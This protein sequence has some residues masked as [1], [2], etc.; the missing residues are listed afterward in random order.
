MAEIFILLKGCYWGARRCLWGERQQKLSKGPGL[1]Q[2]HYTEGGPMAQRVFPKK[3]RRQFHQGEYQGAVWKKKLAHP[4]KQG[5]WWW[6]WP[7]W[8]AAE[9]DN[10]RHFIKQSNKI[11][12]HKSSFKSLRL[13]PPLHTAHSLE[14][15]SL[16]CSRKSPA[17]TTLSLWAHHCPISLLWL[18]AAQPET[19]MHTSK[20]RPGGGLP[21]R[22]P[23]WTCLC[24][25][26]AVL[27]ILCMFLHLPT[28]RVLYLLKWE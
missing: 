3:V 12:N 8:V 28:L 26:R 23:T 22:G 11:P 21:R 13:S 2:G 14:G 20:Q 16:S 19:Y 6:L 5:H 24:H 27:H 1:C 17:W 9:I 4:A 18:G 15:T 7:T 10:Y 25:Q